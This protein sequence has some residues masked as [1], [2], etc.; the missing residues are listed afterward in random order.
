MVKK[1]TKNDRLAFRITEEQ[2]DM[3]DKLIQ[4][5]VYASRSSFGQKA[6]S[7]ILN[8]ENSRYSWEKMISEVAFELVLANKHPSHNVSEL[9]FNQLKK[10]IRDVYD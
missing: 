1:S 3:I 5:G 7:S 8:M 9:L 2:S 6:V 4:Q 10:Y